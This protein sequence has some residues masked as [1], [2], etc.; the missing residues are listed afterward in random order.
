VEPKE[1]TMSQ[2]QQTRSETGTGQVDLLWVGDGAWCACDT[3]LEENDPRRVIAFVECKDH[4][5]D[6]V[7]VRE[8]RPPGR[9]DTLRDAVRAIEASGFLGEE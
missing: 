2:L 3:S 8:Q 4:H 6:V 7:W 9:F 5:V 1:T